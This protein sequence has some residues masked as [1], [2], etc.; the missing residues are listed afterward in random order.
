MHNLEEIFIEQYEGLFNLAYRVLRNQH[1]AE[2]V[3]QEAFI[4]L[5]EN[6]AT[7]T[8]EH[9]ER[10]LRTVTLNLAR[11]RYRRNKKCMPIAFD[12]NFDFNHS[13]FS[14]ETPSSEALMLTQERTNFIHHL[15]KEQLNPIQYKCIHGYYFKDMTYREIS[16]E[17]DICTGTVKSSLCRAKKKLKLPLSAYRGL[18]Q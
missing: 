9:P 13:P 18:E 7:M 10:W 16:L 6:H 5:L 3:T 1:D 11:M 8:I 2:E 4:V 12:E 14:Y 17:E 15:I